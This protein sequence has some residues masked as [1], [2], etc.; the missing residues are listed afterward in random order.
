MIGTEVRLWSP[1]AG[2]EELTNPGHFVAIDLTGQGR[3]ISVLGRTVALPPYGIV[4]G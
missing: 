1:V 2:V 4:T 3:R